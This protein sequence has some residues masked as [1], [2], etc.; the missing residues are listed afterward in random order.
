[1]SWRAGGRGRARQCHA[2]FA[3]GSLP[4]PPHTH[5]HHLPTH[6]F[7]RRFCDPPTVTKGVKQPGVLEG[8]QLNITLSGGNCSLSVGVQG[9][10]LRKSA[11]C[12]GPSVSYSYAPATL[13]PKHWAPDVFTDGGCRVPDKT[14]DVHGLA[15]ALARLDTLGLAGGWG[16][17]S[18]QAAG[19][20]VLYSAGPDV[21]FESVDAFL[22]ALRSGTLGALLGPDA[23]RAVLDQ[24]AASAAQPKAA[25]TQQYPVPTPG[26]SGLEALLQQQGWQVVL[27]PQPATAAGEAA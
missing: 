2:Q 9:G 27:K 11:E 1:M 10:A 15:A 24:Q 7:R 25:P 21:R 8:P 17:A 22:L 6:P 26:S 23:A 19:E 14:L 5:T 16:G 12:W 13:T 3:S 4:P 18:T 20:R